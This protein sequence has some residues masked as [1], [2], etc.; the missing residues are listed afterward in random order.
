MNKLVHVL[1]PFDPTETISISEIQRIASLI[2][3]A[4][5][6]SR[7]MRPYTHALHIITSGYSQ[8]HTKI[9]L[10]TLPQSDIMMRRA[11]VLLLI[12]NPTRLFRPMGTIE[13]F[14]RWHL[15]FAKQPTAHFRFVTCTVHCNQRVKAVE[16][17]GFV[18]VILAWRS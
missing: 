6:L 5:I 3:R 9:K 7:H 14:G 16:H 1:F 15:S 13:R 10:T 17:N 2:S 11:F 18:A 8:P 4:S 12:A